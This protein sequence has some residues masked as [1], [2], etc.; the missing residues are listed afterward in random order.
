MSDSELQR[1]ADRTGVTRSGRAER[2]HQAAVANLVREA[3]FQGIRVD[4]EAV[5]TGRIMERAVDVDN[6]R[7]ALAGGDPVLDSVLTRIEVGF[8]EKAQRIQR[9]FGSEFPS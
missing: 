5:L 2:E 1:W 4:A 8:V 6:Y 9:G 3:K 7:K